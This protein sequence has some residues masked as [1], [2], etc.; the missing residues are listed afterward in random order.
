[1]NIHINNR[2]ILRDLG[3]GLIL[4]RSTADD[5]DAL[6]EFNSHIHSEEGFDKPDLRVGAWTRDL[7]AKPHPTFHADDCTLVVESAT[8]KIISSMNLISQTWAYEGIPFGVG[9]PEL[10]GTLPEYRKRG[11]VRLQFEE[12]HRWSAERG[13]P[14]QGITGIP[15]YYRLFG[16]EMGLEMDG[17]RMGYEAHLPKLKEGE[18][19]PFTLRPASEADLPFLMEVY[20]HACARQLITCVRDETVWRY[21]LTGM[22]EKNIDRLEFRIIQHFEG[23]PVGYVAHPWYNW[24]WGLVARHYELKDNVSWLEVTPSVARYLWQTGETFSKRDGKPQVRTAYGF[25]FGSAHASYDVF[26]NR[27]PLIRDPYAWYIR[28]PDLPVF[29]RLI[30]PALERHITGSAIVGYTGETKISFYR[31]GLLLGFIKG[32]LVTIEPWMPGSDE[33][34]NASFPDQSFLQLVFGYRTFE[35]LEQS[36]AD[37]WY[38]DDETRVLLNTLFPKKPSSVMMVN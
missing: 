36:Y 25:W 37:C 23:E 22:S 6:A 27:L 35:E 30:T 3:N 18:P 10:V 9:R 15:F 20:A 13:E 29:L 26:R 24:N 16:Y 17:G 19:E 28:I 8:G 11:L 4:C 7:L 5:A 21:D 32:R 38:K 31:S 14:V 2:P 12:I 1:M 34:G 33:R